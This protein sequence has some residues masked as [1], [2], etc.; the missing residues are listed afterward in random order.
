MLLYV[1]LEFVGETGFDDSTV[2]SVLSSRDSFDQDDDLAIYNPFQHH[3][4]QSST[5]NASA[6]RAS[7]LIGPDSEQYNHNLGLNESNTTSHPNT[8]NIINN[9][10]L[11]SVTHRSKLASLAKIEEDYVFKWMRMKEKRDRGRAELEARKQRHESMSSFRLIV[12]DI[13]R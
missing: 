10:S 6:S 4:H 1:V 7:R 13:N 9:K 8:G 2:N 3:D 11:W 12:N 5:D